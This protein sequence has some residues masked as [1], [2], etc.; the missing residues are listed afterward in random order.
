M[1]KILCLLLCCLLL[2]GCAAKSNTFESLDPFKWGASANEVSGWQRNKLESSR[3]EDGTVEMVLKDTIY[4]GKKCSMTYTL[5]ED[6]LVKIGYKFEGFS[7]DAEKSQTYDALK[8]Y[9]EKTYGAPS[10]SVAA[11]NLQ[12]VWETQD[13]FV[14]LAA[15]DDR[16]DILIIY[17]HNWRFDI[18]VAS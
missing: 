2:A 3:L 4:D 11:P 12:T 1:K 17:E 10:T 5:K 18:P 9:L 15:P 7:T 8:S 14:G 16:D 6:A 13:L